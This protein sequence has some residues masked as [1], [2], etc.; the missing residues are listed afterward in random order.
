MGKKIDLTGRVFGRLTVLEEAGRNQRG[1]I[2][3][4]C[5]CE[6][7]NTVNVRASNLKSG[8]TQSCGCFSKLD[9][10]GQRFGRLTVLEKVGRRKEGAVIW[11]CQCDCG[12]MVKVCTGS[13]QSGNTKSCGCYNKEQSSERSRIDLTG[14]VYGRLTVSE[15]VGR[16]KR[17]QVIWRCLCECGNFVDVVS[18]SLRNG[19]TQSCGC[20]NKERV[21]ETQCIDLTG[22][23][24]GRLV[25][26]EDVGRTKRQQVIWKC[27]CECGNVVNVITRNLICKNTQSCGCYNRKRASEIHS[28]ENHHNWKGGITPLNHAIRTCSFYIN[29][30]TAVFQRDSYTCQH[31]HQVGENLIA[32]HLN[33]FSDI[34]K[35]N[36][37]TTLEEALQ[38]EALW[39][40]DN[41]LTLCKKCHKKLHSSEGLDNPEEIDYITP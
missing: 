15:D 18:G 29:W 9:L 25:V 39:N 20:Y 19:H 28:G 32:H 13:L 37:I 6:C 17:Q 21:S 38:C 2:L 24:F 4:K 3:W 35:E 26:L 16:T 8:N 1:K 10:T 23:V 40:I 5:L 33:L 12:N 22:Q 34:M 11:E 7:G 41:G 27:Q 31:C 36:N 14:Q 30:R